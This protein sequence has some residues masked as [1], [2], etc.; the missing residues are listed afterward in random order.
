MFGRRTCNKAHHWSRLRCDSFCSGNLVA[1]FCHPIRSNCRTEVADI[2]QT[3]QVIPY[4]TREI[5]FGKY[6]SKLVFGVD[7]LNLDF[8]VQVDSIEQPIKRNSVG[9]GDM[10]RCCPQTHTAKLLDAKTGRLM[11]HNQCFSTRWSSLEIFESCH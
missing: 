9:P 7:V 5:S 6:V 3:Q 2:E 8:G 10:S 4:V 11:E 1:F